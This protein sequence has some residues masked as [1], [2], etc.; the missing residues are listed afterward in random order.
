MKVI[1]SIVHKKKQFRYLTLE[2]YVSNPCF[3]CIFT[4]VKDAHGYPYTARESDVYRRQI[5][6]SKVDSRTKRVKQL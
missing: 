3:K 4:M 1:V 5:L 6:T 2:A